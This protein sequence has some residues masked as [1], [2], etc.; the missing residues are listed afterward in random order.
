MEGVKKGVGVGEI[1]EEVH[2]PKSAKEFRITPR[3]VGGNKCQVT[4]KFEVFLRELPRKIPRFYK[5]LQNLF[6]M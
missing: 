1:E 5:G 2:C 6:R 3:N 4:D